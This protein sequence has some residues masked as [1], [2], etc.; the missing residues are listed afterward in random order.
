MSI[1]Q[2][3]KVHARVAPAICLVCN[4]HGVFR[5]GRLDNRE[6]INSVLVSFDESN[7][8]K[9]ELEES[10]SKYGN[11]SDSEYS[12]SGNDS[13]LNEFDR[14]KVPKMSTPLEWRTT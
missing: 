6:I 14:I 2:K 12:G 11:K 5:V 1:F 13:K 3:Y 4:G 9:L 7:F 8:P 10:I